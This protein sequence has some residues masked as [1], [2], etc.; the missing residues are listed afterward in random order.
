VCVRLR[1]STESMTWK[2]FFAA[3]KA[4]S[5]EVKRPPSPGTTRHTPRPGGS[6]GDGQA[7][8]SRSSACAPLRADTTFTLKQPGA[9]RPGHAWS[10]RR[11]S[12]TARPCTMPRLHMGYRPTV[13]IIKTRRTASNRRAARLCIDEGRRGR[14]F[15]RSRAHG[16]QTT[17]KAQANPGRARER[18]LNP[19]GSRDNPHH[20]DI[21]TPS[22]TRPQDT[23]A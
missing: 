12:P 23:S 13:R 18:S 11:K 1:L 21:W 4:R 14:R 2:A 10:T 20:R 9:E 17:L 19:L 8:C 22:C 7:R 6:F 16:P 5:I 15:H 3:L